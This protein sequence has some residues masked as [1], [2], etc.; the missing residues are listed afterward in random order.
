M[1]PNPN[2]QETLVSKVGKDEEKHLVNR[3]RGG[4]GERE[5]QYSLFLVS[6]TLKP[7]EGRNRNLKQ[8][9]NVDY[10]VDAQIINH[11]INFLY[12]QPSENCLIS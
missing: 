5:I 10:E 1:S 3:E 8:N 7:G 9:R 6:S 2:Q 4:E 11:Y 12:E